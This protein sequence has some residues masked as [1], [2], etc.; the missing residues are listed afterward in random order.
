MEL[1]GITRVVT[2]IEN[3]KKLYE[4]ILGFDTDA[5]YAPTKWQSYKCQPGVYFA[6]GEA[7]GSTNEISFA[8]D[9]LEALWLR[10][11]EQADIVSPLEETPWGTYRFVI[12]DP[13]G[14]FLSFCQ[15]Q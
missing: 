5:Y 15:K 1:I 2:H 12:K 9:D 13:D 3:S 4:D 11:K 6:I 14:N 8:V 7:P 10:I